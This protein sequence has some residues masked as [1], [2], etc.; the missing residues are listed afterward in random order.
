MSVF[1]VR[2]DKAAHVESSHW[3]LLSEALK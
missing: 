2:R 1:H 3:E